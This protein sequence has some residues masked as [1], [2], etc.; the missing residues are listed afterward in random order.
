MNSASSSLLGI[1]FVLRYVSTC[2]RESHIRD[3][4]DVRCSRLTTWSGCFSSLHHPGL[5]SLFPFS[6][7]G[8]TKSGWLIISLS[9]KPGACSTGLD[10]ERLAMGWAP[11][12]HPQSRLQQYPLMWNLQDYIILNHCAWSLHRMHLLLKKVRLC[13]SLPIVS[14]G[15]IFKVPGWGV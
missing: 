9:R 14:I 13:H 11:Q 5:T 8:I 6:T 15:P 10:A 12:P 4:L 7:N 2:F 1:K 3:L